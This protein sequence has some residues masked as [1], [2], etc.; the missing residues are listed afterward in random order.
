[1]EEA[2]LHPA[3]TKHVSTC[4]LRSQGSTANA[5]KSEPW[6]RLD[7]FC[8]RA[9]EHL[10]RRA[11]RHEALRCFRTLATTAVLLQ[12]KRT[13]QLTTVFAMIV[14]LWSSGCFHCTATEH[15]A[16]SDRK[17]CMSTNRHSTLIFVTKMLRAHYCYYYYYYCYLLLLLFLLFWQLLLLLPLTL[18]ILLL[19]LLFLQI[20]LLFLRL[21]REK[22]VLLLRLLLL[23]LL[24]WFLLLELPLLPPQL[25]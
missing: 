14:L 5:A 6:E 20:L 22:K 21:L 3:R 11:W 19:F 17:H 23:L 15:N 9:N 24:L 8:Y 13:L 10:S 16:H 18:K 2:S 7:S 12:S 1:M 4:C 25:K